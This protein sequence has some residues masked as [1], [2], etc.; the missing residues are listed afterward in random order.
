MRSFLSSGNTGRLPGCYLASLILFFCVTVHAE[1]RLPVI[2]VHVHAFIADWTTGNAPI[3]PA[4]GQPSAAATGDDL[5]AETLDYMKRYNVV[6]GI[7]SGSLPAI[8]EWV[9]ADPQRF[10]GAPIFPV[11]FDV[12]SIDE[13]P[14]TGLL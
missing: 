6:K 10:I 7:V 14:D 3:N 2:D 5:L 13:W 4:T 12:D 8:E 9:E 11:G 1:T